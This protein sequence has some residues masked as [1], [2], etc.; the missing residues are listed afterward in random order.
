LNY[1]YNIP[2]N[3]QIISSLQLHLGRLK[4]IRG[5]IKRLNEGYT[6]DDIELFE[7]K[8]LAIINAKVTKLLSDEIV[9]M[10]D[11]PDL[12][13]IISLLDPEKTG[14]SSFYVYDVYDSELADLR[15][16]VK[17]ES[18]YQNELMYQC[19]LLE[20]KVRKKLT[21][22]IS[23]RIDKINES[24]SCLARLDILMSKADQLLRLG[25]TFPSIAENKT[26]YNDLFNPHLK[27]ILEQ[28]NKSYQHT[29]ISFRRGVPLLITG[30]NMG[31]KSVT[32]KTLELS[33]V[34]FQFGFGI[35]AKESSIVPVEQI[36]TSSG[37]HEDTYKGL[38]S[39]AAEIKKINS[40]IT[41][42]RSKKTIL[43]LIDEPAR[44]TNPS[45]GA[46]LASALISSFYDSDSFLV[47]TT[48]YTL[49]NP[50][51]DRIRVRGFVEGKMNYT[52]ISDTSKEPPEEAIRI[53]EDL[54]ADIE[55][56][57]QARVY[58]NNIKSNKYAK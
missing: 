24:L 20:E 29:S 38:S 9:S 6:A 25:L 57:R 42:M 31:G 11:I 2:R 4:D 23:K 7:I 56:I 39:F 53:A 10:L 3:K 44:T 52:L 37:D 17:N 14:A 22:V 5:T 43:G 51:C 28:N 49:D 55:W 36:S 34:L 21:A 15:K 18:R 1:I 40:M 8:N 27:I 41:S 33:Q 48:H 30:A 46:A 16:R 19:D 50:K 45:E 58:L 35:P 26:I 32:M 47:M 54:G 12:N 13:E